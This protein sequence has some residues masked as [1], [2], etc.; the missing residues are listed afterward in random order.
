MIWR[1]ENWVNPNISLVTLRPVDDLWDA[2]EAGAD[3]IVEDVIE[4]IAKVGNPY[5]D[6][7]DP[8]HRSGFE[9]CRQAILS[10][11]KGLEKGDE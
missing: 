4:D 7:L 5:N 6:E 10:L 2:Y 9:A 3:A 11:L 1:P 8:L